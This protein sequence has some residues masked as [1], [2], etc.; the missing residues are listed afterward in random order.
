MTNFRKFALTG[1]LALALGSTF[2]GLASAQSA[3]GNGGGAGAGG[4]TDIAIA[5]D[6]G[7]SHAVAPGGPTYGRGSAAPQAREYHCGYQLFRGRYC[8]PTRR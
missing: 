3:G 8:E 6:P 4:A 5:V 2:S 1:A 7:I